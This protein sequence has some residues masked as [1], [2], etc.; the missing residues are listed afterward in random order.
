MIFKIGDKKLKVLIVASEV[1][2]Y[3]KTGG[4]ADVC[5]A[6]PKALLKKGCDVRVIMPLYKEVLHNTRNIKKIQADIY[7]SDL[8]HFEKFDLYSHEEGDLTTYFIDNKKFF[9]RDELY[10]T[11]EGDYEDNAQRFA[12]FSKASLAAVKAIGF[13][14]DIMHLNDWQTALIPM[15]LKNHLKNDSFYNEIKTLFTIHNLA[16]HGQFPKE[17]LKE[18]DIPRHLFNMHDMEFYGKVNF[19]K[20][21]L[22][23]SDHLSTVSK[24]YA[25]EILTEEYGCGLAGV[26]NLRRDVLRGITNGVDYLQW[27][28][29]TDIY[30]KEN[31]SAEH[32]HEKI[33]CKK[34]L[35]DVVGLNIDINQP[36]FG[37]ITRLAWQKGLDMFDDI[38]ENILRMGAGIVVLG[39]GE[40]EIEDKLEQLESA[41]PGQISVNIKFDNALAHKIEGGS[42]FFLMPSRYEPC[43]LNQMYS[44]RYGTVPVVR[45]TGG[46]DDVI[47][48]IKE[49]P[50]KGNGFKFGPAEKEA[51][52][53]AVTRAI[54]FYKD[55]IKFTRLQEKIMKEDYSWDMSADR[56]IGL[57]KDICGK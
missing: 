31:F 52:L 20:S 34:D 1:A 11:S 2:P 54:N 40:K 46:L 23:Y 3:A 22:L 39:K 15:Y 44:L 43:G 6:L 49:N 38:C 57:Y 27:D 4:L 42:D 8:G 53:E 12:F 28:P 36:L 13:K 56:Y 35:I 26:L 10:C 16:Y 21:G 14:C 18:V 33:I 48:D 32:L 5:G 24:G 25:K 50:E 19:L 45:A 9:D 29:S 47:V 37:I 7:R 51:F 30:L 41:F 55:K 17:I